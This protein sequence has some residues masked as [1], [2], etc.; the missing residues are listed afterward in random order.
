MKVRDVVEA[1]GLKVHSGATLLDRDVHGGYA[2]DLLSD[3]LAHAREGMI[4]VTLHTHVNVV[5]V[6][7]TKQLS[8]VIIVNGRIPDEGTTRAAV[9][10]D[11]PL[12]LTPGGTFQTVSKLSRLGIG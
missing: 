5:A 6:A 8:A 11:V 2:G 3:V 9:E 10:N 4:W 7:S 1:I 12:L